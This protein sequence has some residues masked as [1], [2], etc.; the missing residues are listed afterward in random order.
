MSPSLAAP[1]IQVSALRPLKPK[2]GL[3]GAP[4]ASF[5]YSQDMGFPSVLFAGS[6]AALLCVSS[7][8]QTMDQGYGQQSQQAAPAQAPAAQSSTPQL[9]LESLP[10]DPHTP[11]PEELAAEELAQKR[12]QIQRVAASMAN[13]GPKMSSQGV[14]LTMKEVSR[15]NVASG[16]MLTYRLLVSGFAPGTRLTL[17][18]WPLNQAVTSVMDGIVIDA[19]GTAVCGPPTSTLSTPSGPE[20]TSQPATGAGSGGAAGSNTV[21]SCAKTMQANAPVEITATAAKGEAIRVGLLSEDRKTGAAAS[22][23]PFPITGVDRGCKLSVL[24]GSKDAELVLIEGDGFKPDLP[25]TA[26]TE[27]FGQKTTLSA[28]VN[29]QGHFLAAM[30]PYVEGH[31]SGDTVIYYQSDACTPTVSFHWGKGSY[32]AE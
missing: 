28:K 24:L 4:K 3:S 8:A 26:G 10:P 31:D 18:R 25:F 16:T 17:M 20:A 6:L 30:T 22:V 19:S 2:P 5:I 23:V 7:S 27:T 12:A 15:E 13:W 9:K 14:T 21:P 11:T 32:K 1:R 29:A